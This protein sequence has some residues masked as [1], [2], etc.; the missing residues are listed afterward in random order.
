MKWREIIGATG[1][2]KPKVRLD[3]KAWRRESERRRKVNQRM[4]HAKADCAR[5]VARIRRDET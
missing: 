4:A 2:I 3:T 5:K 1:T